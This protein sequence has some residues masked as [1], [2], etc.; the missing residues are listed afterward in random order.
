MH[1]NIKA[2]VAALNLFL[3]AALAASAPMANAGP[4]VAASPKTSQHASFKPEAFERIAVIVKPIQAQTSGS[5][6][7][8][9]G[10]GG[11]GGMRGKQ[12]HQ[13]QTGLERLVE[14]NFMRVL[15]GEGYT[16]VSRADLDAAMVEKG[17]TQ[18]NLTD[19]TFTQEAGKLLH[20]SAIMVVSVDTF[21]TTRLQRQVPRGQGV[22]AFGNNMQEHF[23]VSA[24][25][26]ARLVKISDNMVMWTGDYALSGTFLAQDQD[27]AML[28]S[29]AEAIAKSF[30]SI[31]AKKE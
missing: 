16:L 19:E 28:A 2:P 13:E 20:V 4:V 12:Q 26:G 6:G 11:T 22:P 21:T 25:L 3:A 29:M 1:H 7:M 17:L 30:P 31:P 8:S 9:F 24:S 15:L 14:Q 18:A 10:I 5:I 27:R 23:Q